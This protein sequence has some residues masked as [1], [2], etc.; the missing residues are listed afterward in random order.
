MLDGP[1]KKTGFQSDG[2]VACSPELCAQA[3]RGG[4]APSRDALAEVRPL[5]TLKRQLLGM[6]L[7]GKVG[8][9]THQSL[10]DSFLSPL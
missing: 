5:W 3:L 4:V 10:L 8:G 9:L 6:D 1:K 2:Q 7:D